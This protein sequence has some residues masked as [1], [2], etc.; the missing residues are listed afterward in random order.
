VLAIVLP[1]GQSLGTGQFLA[2]DLDVG[3]VSRVAV[4][5]GQDFV[6]T[7]PSVA[8]HVGH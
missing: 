3:M 7:A 4:G 5:D 6:A 8:R 1:D 2:S